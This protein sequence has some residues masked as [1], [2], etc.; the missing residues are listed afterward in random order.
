MQKEKLTEFNN[1]TEPLASVVKRL[2]NPVSSIL[3]NLPCCIFRIPEVDGI[4]GYQK[5]KN[6]AVVI[7]DPICLPQNIDSLTRAFQFYCQKQ[8]LTIVYLLASDS[9][10]H[11][12]INNGFQTLIQVG[13]KLI[14]NPTKFQKRQKLRWKINQSL[15]NGVIVKEYKN[16]DP[17]IENQIRITTNIWLKNKNGPQ[18]YLGNLSPLFNDK[19]QRFFYAL[20]KDRIIGLLN[21]S[22]IDRF[23]GWVVNSFLAISDA[24][25]GTTEHLFS[26]IIE[27]L[28][29]EGCHFLCL[30]AVS[31]SNLGEMVGLNPFSKYMAHLIFKIA[32]WFFKLEGRKTYLNKYH[33]H[34]NPTYFLISGKLTLKELMAIKEVLNVT[35]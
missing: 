12:G 15:Q 28:G 16:F 30:G 9:F 27:T 33:P 25:V 1:V 8:N 29:N 24:P 14:I 19:G 5:V 10:A 21:L 20:Q 34:F 17:S 6:C 4:I 18:I 26:S 7:G 23:Q 35:L 13:Q 32:K 11:W 2:G 3:L 22:R 31:G